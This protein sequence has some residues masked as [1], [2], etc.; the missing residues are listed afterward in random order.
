[1]AH[2][3]RRTALKEFRRL[4][5][6]YAPELCA[7]RLMNASPGFVRRGLARMNAAVFNRLPDPLADLS[8]RFVSGYGRM[9]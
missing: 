4:N 5:I 7:R 9:G 6:L 2:E 3:D 1:M 8:Y